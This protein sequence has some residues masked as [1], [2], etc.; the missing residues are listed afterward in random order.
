MNA[1][2]RTHFDT[3]R[4]ADRQEQGAAYSYLLEATKKPV[5][6]AYEV[7]DEL[8]AG[9]SHKDNRVRSISAQ[10]LCNLAKSDPKGRMLK[11]FRSSWRTRKTRSS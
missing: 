5:D 6:W 9:L 1:T 3:I 7:W 2:M 11:D 10:L 8:V 4:S